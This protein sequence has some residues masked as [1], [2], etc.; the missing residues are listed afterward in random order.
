M[1][2]DVPGKPP[3]TTTAATAHPERTQAPT[4]VLRTHVEAGALA[5]WGRSAWLSAS[6]AFMVDCLA[7]RMGRTKKKI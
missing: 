3:V 2:S 7:G 6:T 1:A 5:R 4:I